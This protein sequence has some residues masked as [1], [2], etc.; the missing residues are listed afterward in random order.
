MEIADIQK[1]D[2]DSGR[3]WLLPQGKEYELEEIH[4]IRG[5]HLALHPD[6]KWLVSVGNEREKRERDKVI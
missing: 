5:A 1:Y 3:S 2:M 6:V 4:I